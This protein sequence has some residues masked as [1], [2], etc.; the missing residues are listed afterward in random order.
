MNETIRWGFVGCGRIAKLMI[1]GLKMV[2]DAR[3][4]AVFDGNS[5]TAERFAREEGIE[6]I[7]SNI[8][9]FL[10]SGLFDVVYIALPHTFHLEFSKLAMNTGFPVLCE[11]PICPNA[12]QVS[13]LIDCAHKNNVFLMEAFWQRF[14]PASRQVCDWIKQGEIGRIVA[15]NCIFAYKGPFIP[16]ERIYE[17]NLAGGALLDIGCYIVNFMNMVFGCQPCEI[18]SVVNLAPC[19]VDDSNAICFKYQDG[20]MASMISTFFGDAFE[21]MTILGDKGV[22]HIDEFWWR[23]HDATLKNQKG[24]YRYESAIQ[25]RGFQYEVKHVQESLLKGLKE[26]PIM[27]LQDSL[28][29]TITMDKLRL[30]WGLSYPFEN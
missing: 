10:S 26:S 27:P 17:K 28:D 7:F 30:D 5:Q 15:A 2:Q 16:G 24:T 23:P 25:G 14:F 12:S 4:T 9:S 8:N 3:V 6:H 21:G 13:E 29:N 11:K 19:G 1:A 22:I 18:A 20:A